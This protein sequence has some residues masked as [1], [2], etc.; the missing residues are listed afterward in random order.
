MGLFFTEIF[1]IEPKTFSLG[2]KRSIR[3]SYISI[4]IYNKNRIKMMRF[5]LYDG[6]RG[7]RTHDPLIKSQLLCQLSYVPNIIKLVYSCHKKMSI[8]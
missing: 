7:D 6:S 3:L 8:I 2:G 4:G 1:G 5:L